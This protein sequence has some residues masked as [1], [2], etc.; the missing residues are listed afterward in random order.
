M[1]RQCSHELVT[2][3]EKKLR[4]IL[5]KCTPVVKNIQIVT[6]DLWSSSTDPAEKSKIPAISFI[7]FKSQLECYTLCFFVV[8]HS[9]ENCPENNIHVLYHSCNHTVA[10]HNGQR[11]HALAGSM[12]NKVFR[13]L[14][15]TVLHFKQRATAPFIIYFFVV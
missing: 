9:N 10:F 6:Y 12:S 13:T 2:H 5:Y 14:R 11:G 4:V 1:I 8:F 15:F 7:L 3:L